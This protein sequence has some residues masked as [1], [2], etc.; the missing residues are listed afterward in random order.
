MS[1]PPY[2]SEFKDQVVRE[3]QETQNATLVAR[4]HQLSPGMV[5]RWVRAARQQDRENGGMSSIKPPNKAGQ[6]DAMTGV[7]EG[8]AGGGER[9]M[10]GWNSLSHNPLAWFVH[11][12]PREAPGPAIND[13]STN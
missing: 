12:M 7:G 3:V 2:S 4:R 5:R 10:I 9:G 1:T 8:P 6:N 11:I 13:L